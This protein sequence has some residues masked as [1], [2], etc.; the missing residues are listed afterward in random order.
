MNQYRIEEFKRLASSP[1]NHQFTLL[2]LAYECGFNSKSSF[3]RYFKKSTGVTPS[4]Y[5]AQ[6]T[7]K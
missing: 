3:N 6:I 1:K 7:N 2:S 4:Q 5:F